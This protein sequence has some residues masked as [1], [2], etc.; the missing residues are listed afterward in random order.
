MSGDS[1]P[2]VTAMPEQGP[3]RHKLGDRG[4]GSIYLPAG[5]RVW[6]LACCVDGRELRK[7]TNQTDE[8]KARKFA[9]EHIGSLRRGECSPYED[10]VTLA[11]LLAKVERDYDLNKRRSKDIIKHPLRHLRAG[12]GEDTRAIALTGDRVTRYILD[13]RAA[14]AANATIRIELALLGKGFTLAVRDRTLRV[15]PYIPKPNGDPSRVRQG[16]FT[17]EEVEKLCTPCDC[18]QDAIGAR[19]WHQKKA[20]EHPEVTPCWHLPPTVADMVSFLFWSTWRV[21]EARELQ[22]R[23]YDRMEHAIR[24]R[25]EH[26]KN[27]HGRVL[28]LVGELA[29]IM[30]RRLEARRLECPYIFHQDGKPLGD[31]RKAWATACAAIGLPGRIVHD[32]RRSGV[33]HL[34]GAGVD[35]HTVMAF[36]G[37]RTRSM[38]DRYHIIALDD[39]RVAA[40]KGAAYQG[41][42]AQV[43]ALGIRKE[44]GK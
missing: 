3:R 20:A 17:R 26:S 15:K 11:D 5:S 1:S 25:P 42:A 35:P 33:K 38:L 10:K 39:L 4:E 8:K 19:F 32:L 7:S 9:K 21:G 27:K 28:P 12:L 22:W 44:V 43:T 31:I 41:R 23:D 36:S 14:G 2:N 16:F 40:E 18:T 13:R 6:W 24:L 37:H 29:A 30:T 34:I